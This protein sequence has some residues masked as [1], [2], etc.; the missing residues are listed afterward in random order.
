MSNNKQNK[1][2]KHSASGIIVFFN[3]EKTVS[4]VC[5]PKMEGL[6]RFEGRWSDLAATIAG[7]RSYHSFEI[8]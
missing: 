2:N 4:Q 3:E 6:N 5:R 8:I 7:N 1:V